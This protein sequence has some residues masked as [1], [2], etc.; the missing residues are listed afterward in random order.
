MKTL[1]TR[2]LTMTKHHK[3][4]KKPLKMETRAQQTVVQEG[5]QHTR[6][7]AEDKERH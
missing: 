3:D 6:N 2:L 4:R 5:E 7:Q 1:M